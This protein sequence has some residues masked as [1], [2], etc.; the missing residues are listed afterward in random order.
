VTTGQLL[1]LVGTTGRSSSAHA[2]FEFIVNGEWVD[3]AD[4]IQ[5]YIP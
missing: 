4:F 3:A 5:M 1:G 2:H